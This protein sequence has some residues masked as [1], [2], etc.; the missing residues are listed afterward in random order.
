MSA[1]NSIINMFA[2]HKVASNL[3][4]IMMILSGLWAA[5]RINTQ[6]D[7]SAEFPVIV[8]QA[9]WPGASAEDLEQLIVVPVEQ[10]IANMTDLESYQSFSRNGSATIIARFYFDSDISK[11]LNFVKNRVTQIRNFPADMEPIQISQ[12]ID[13]EEIAV[14]SVSSDGTLQELMPLVREMEDELYARGI[15]RIVFD[16]MPEEEI[17]IQV[18]SSRL[19]EL[20][21][22]LEQIASEVRQRSANSPAGTVGRGQAEMQLRSLDQK[23]EV[24]EFQQMQ[25]A[26]EADGR[27]ARLTDIATIDKRPK[28]GQPELY[29][30]GKVSIEME[31]YRLKS[32][33]A[34]DTARIVNEWIAETEPILPRGVEIH[35]YQEAWL[36]LKE[37]LRVIFENGTSGLILVLLTL[38]L[39]LNGRVG[40]WVMIGIPVS[41]LFATLIFYGVFGGSI[42]ILALI[43]F[44]MALGIVVDDAIVVSEDAV[45]LFEQGM[46]PSDAA[47]NGAK[48][49]LLPVLTSSMT[50]LAAFVP[51]ILAGGEMGAII[52]TMPVVLLCVIIASLIE[53]FFVLPGHLRHAF[54]NTD[55][56]KPSKFRQKFDRWFYSFRDNYYQPLLNKS[57]AAPGTTLCAAL[58]CVILSISLIAGGRV[59]LNLVTGMSL[60]MLEANVKF[61]AQASEADR[62]DYMLSL[63]QELDRIDAANGGT[64][65]NGYISKTNSARLNQERKTGSQYSS[66]RI[67]YGWEEDR[68][69]PPQQFVNLWQAAVPPSPLVEELYLEVRGGANGGQPDLTLILRGRDIPT[70]KQASEELQD[71]LSAYPG[72]SNVYDNLP[73]GKDQIIYSINAA[74]K[75]LGITTESL[76]RQLRA[77]Y[78]GGRVQIFNQHDSEIEVSVMLPD[79][80]RDSLHS[81]KQFPIQTPS[82][83]LVAMGLIA[84]IENRSG[85]DLINHSNG[86]MSVAVSASVDPLQNNTEQ[87]VTHVTDNALTQIREKYNLTSDLGGVSRQNQELLDTLKTG[88]LLTVIF[89]YLILAWSFSSY[90]W[91]LAVMTAIPLGLTG[92]IVGHWVMG[93]DIGAMSLLAFFSLTGIVVNDSIIL[94]SFFRRELA[95]GKP[96]KEAIHDASIARFRAVILTSLTTIAGLSPLMFETFSLAMYIVPIAIT[97]C[98]GLAFSTLLV[99]VVIPALLVMIE[100]ASIKLR[101]LSP[102][103]RLQSSVELT[104]GSGANSV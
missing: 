23:R 78:N 58:A 49:M 32:S 100:N 41:F 26:V 68:S 70:L 83:E 79:D 25:V 30:E 88:A 27:L 74:G 31:L 81:L 15:E 45:T 103:T 17:A 18:S 6:L 9:T 92:A 5:D 102:F 2:N 56:N 33:D 85:I 87:V 8:I 38:F 4:M 12:E 57:L 42:N 55:R 61:S 11:N 29:R 77:A 69:I 24:A 14:I 16:G 80:E 90:I 82:G 21:T 98:F 13:Y 1:S 44:I 84:D 59:G 40:W 91:P 54:E 34:I 93:A 97:L 35:K 104:D 39:F 36:L 101:Q 67:E 28:V 95:A 37:Q 7:P 72:V 22:N 46:S 86:F 65:I 3:V 64:N 71:A 76:G 43:T 89:I 94:V 60:E 52:T 48:R 10:Q 47:A 96:Y 99:L 62:Q 63:E 53:C 51:L 73:Y 50:T 66:I 75:S 19:I 20:D